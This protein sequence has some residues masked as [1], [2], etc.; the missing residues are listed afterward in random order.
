MAVAWANIPASELADR[1][2]DLPMLG[3]QVIPVSPTHAK[4]VEQA[5]VGAD[6]L[7]TWLNRGATAAPTRWTYDGYGHRKSTVAGAADDVWFLRFDL[8][9]EY[10][11]DYV[12]LIN[13]DFDTD[14]VDDLEFEIATHNDFGLTGSLYTAGAF[15]L[16]GSDKRL[17]LADLDHATVGT[18]QRYTGVR[19]CGIKI[20]HSTTGGNIVPQLGEIFI[21]RTYQLGHTPRAPWDDVSLAENVDWA[22]TESGIVDQEIYYRRRFDLSAALSEHETTHITDLKEF[23]R[24]TRGPFVW[25]YEPN[26]AL[27]SW[28]FMMRRGGLRFPAQGFVERETVI[29]AVEQGGQNLYLDV[30]ANG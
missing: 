25:C 30:E 1:A 8:G 21:G 16:R 20:D 14:G 4:W 3:S 23:Y 12:A 22:D 13:H 17:I 26:S 6:D 29:E 9:A 5:L 18:P 10:D 11:I 24:K 28:H 2:A 15:S 7:P 19:Y 27:E